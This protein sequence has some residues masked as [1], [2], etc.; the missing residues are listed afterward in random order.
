L[1]P[2]W[3]LQAFN[4][5]QQPLT[6]IDLQLKNFNTTPYLLPVNRLTGYKIYNPAS[7]CLYDDEYVWAH[8]S[9][10]WLDHIGTSAPTWNAGQSY[11]RQGSESV[12]AYISR[13]YSTSTCAALNPTLKTA[14]MTAYNYVRHSF[15]KSPLS[16]LP[17]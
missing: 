1:T 13:I 11:T 14:F 5:V 3:I 15:L 8:I 6:D 17:T 9:A 4:Y 2:A 7:T 10:P 16:D 12:D